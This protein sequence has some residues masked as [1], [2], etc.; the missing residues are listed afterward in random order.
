MSHFECVLKSQAAYRSGEPV[1]LEFELRNLSE[2]PRF[3]LRW[4]T[5]FEGIAGK[6]FR[7]Q[8][9]GDVVAYRGILAKRGEPMAEDYLEV[10]GRG[11]I[12]ASVEL[13]ESYDLSPPGNY[14]IAFIA[15]L[16]DVTDRREEVPRRRDDHQPE[17]LDCGTARFRVLQA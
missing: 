8:R 17:P 11:T 2:S 10:P 13:A 3:V 4:Y 12:T 6:I 1:T 15:G 5:P 14:E 9:N 16:H 7:V